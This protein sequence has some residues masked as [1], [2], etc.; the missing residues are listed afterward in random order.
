MRLNAD[1]LSRSP[2][3]RWTAALLGLL[4]LGLW[5]SPAPAQESPSF[6]LPIA[7]T[8]GKDCWVQN[9]FDHDPGKGA[10]DFTCGHLTYDTH[11][12]TDIRVA[13]YAAMRKGVPVLAAAP[14]VVLRLRDGMADVNVRDIGRAA[15]AG[16]DAGNSVVIGHGDGWE[17]QYAHMRKGSIEVKVGQHVEA[18]Q[19]IGLV[20]LS[21]DTEF[22]HVH[23]SVRYKGGSI[24]PFTGPEDD[25]ACGKAPHPMWNAKTEQEIAYRPSGV[26]SAGLV[27]RRVNTQDILEGGDHLPAPTR[28]GALI[29][30]YASPFGVRAGDI[31]DIRLIG[32]DGTVLAKTSP[33]AKQDLAVGFLLVGAKIPA[34]GWPPGKYR[35]EYELIRQ[36]E[37]QAKPVAQAEREFVLQ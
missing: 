3:P 32:P 13:D 1:R 5:A 7:C 11:N 6:G 31:Q 24:D 17:T 21:G 33:V 29:A 14:G 34:G 9:Y 4:L 12:G 28:E 22:P 8:I 26:I 37:G 23:F 2:F 27:D 16:R 30:F 35:G 36:V 15:L 25:P 18:G 20:G 10:V 19:E